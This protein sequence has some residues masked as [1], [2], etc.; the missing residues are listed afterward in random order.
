MTLYGFVVL[1]IAQL[2]GESLS[3][4]FGLPVPGPVLALMAIALLFWRREA[5]PQPLA[6]AADALL[7]HLSLLFIPA[8]VGVLQ[9]LKLLREEWFAIVATIALSTALTLIVTAYVF[10]YL[11]PA[12]E[13]GGK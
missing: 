10:V 9:H 13:E 11:S 3:Q 1:V 4:A 2:A 5:I 6:D 7:R 8:G 12:K